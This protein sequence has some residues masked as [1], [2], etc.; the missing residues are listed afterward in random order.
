M[1]GLTVSFVSPWH[2]VDAVDDLRRVLRDPNGAT[3]TRTWVNAHGDL[4]VR[5]TA[6]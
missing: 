5:D 4:A 3:Q 1:C 2:D 6:S